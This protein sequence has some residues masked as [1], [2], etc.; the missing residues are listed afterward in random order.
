[1]KEIRIVVP[2]RVWELLEKI[3][4]EQKIRKEDIVLRAII[5]VL[6]TYLGERIYVS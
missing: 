4:K 5:R 6:E 3:E 2:D 1:M